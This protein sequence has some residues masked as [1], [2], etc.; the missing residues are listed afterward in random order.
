MTYEGFRRRTHELIERE[1][2]TSRLDYAIDLF[3]TLLIVTNVVAVMLET[4][5][6]IGGPYEPYFAAFEVFS[7]AV[8]TAEYALRL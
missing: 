6:W 2:G 4:V 7:V 8:F 3:I 1:V 5:V